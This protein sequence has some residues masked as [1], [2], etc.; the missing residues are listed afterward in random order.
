LIHLISSFPHLRSDVILC[1][2]VRSSESGPWTQFGP[3]E[4]QSRDMKELMKIRVEPPGVTC[5]DP[6]EKFCSLDNPYL[7][8]DECDASSPDLSHPPQLMGDRERG[9]L[10]TYWQTVTWSRFPEPLLANVT[11]SWNKTL[12]TTDDIIITFESGRPSALV[13]DKSLDRGQTWQPYQ[14]YADDCLETFGMFPKKVSDLSPSNLTRVICTEEYSQWVGAKEEKQ[15]VFEV[16]SRF[17]VLAGPKL[18]NMDSVWTRL[19]SSPGLRDFFSFTDLRLRLLRPAL[20][21][22][23]VQK[24]QLLKYFYAI[25][26]VQVPA[27]CKCNLHASR[28]LLQDS[29][30]VCDCDHFTTGADCERCRQGFT[31]QPW[32]AGSYLPL[33][34]GAANICETLTSCNDHSNRCSFIDFLEVVTCVSCKHN[35]RGTKCHLCRLGYYRNDSVPMSNE[36]ACT[37]CRCDPVGSMSSICSETGACPC[38]T[39]TTGRR[40]DSC[41]PGYNW[42][43]R[44]C[45]ENIC[46][47]DQLLCQNGGTCMDFTKCSCPSNYTGSFCEQEL[48]LE[49]EGCS[50][51]ATDSAPQPFMATPL[52][53][54]LFL[55]LTR[56]APS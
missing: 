52:Y 28:C 40:C 16:R 1:L 21:G 8:S 15:V 37:E 27:R 34:Q 20:G 9:G 31:R 18:L 10:V 54:M 7:C 33:P 50:Q 47:E 2:F 38:K 3:C 24:D 43:E 51:E 32:R 26:N 45:A 46:D 12:E 41:L 14:F 44:G 19:D 36:Q 48:C 17:S 42:R 25:S 4:P 13:L 35:T 49:T 6:P 39:G 53:L 30:L 55:L 11:L 29:A 23:Y 56:H 5:G 22:T